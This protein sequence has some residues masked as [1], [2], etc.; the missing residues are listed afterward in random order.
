MDAKL[1][2]GIALSYY[3]AFKVKTQGCHLLQT[4][5]SCLCSR[6]RALYADAQANDTHSERWDAGEGVAA[7]AFGV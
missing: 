4:G 7:A 5:V 3:T 6:F 2:G 1:P